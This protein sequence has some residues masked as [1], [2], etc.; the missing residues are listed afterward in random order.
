ME[1]TGADFIHRLLTERALGLLVERAEPGNSFRYLNLSTAENI[2]QASFLHD[3]RCQDDIPD[4]AL[5]AKIRAVAEKANAKLV[6]ITDFTIRN[7]ILQNF[8][9]TMVSFFFPASDVMAFF[10]HCFDEPPATATAE[11]GK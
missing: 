9:E 10:V 3:Q 6:P 4:A 2:H 11:Q 1:L 7:L 8:A 5:D